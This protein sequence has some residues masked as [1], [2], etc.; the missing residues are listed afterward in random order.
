MLVHLFRTEDEVLRGHLHKLIWVEF[1]EVVMVLQYR[2]SH[3]EGFSLSIQNGT[4]IQDFLLSYLDDSQRGTKY[5]LDLF[6]PE[7]V[8]HS[9]KQL[10]RKNRAE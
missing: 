9:Q 4:Y 6:V 1:V 10:D 8:H 5:Y 2:Y 7:D 3:I